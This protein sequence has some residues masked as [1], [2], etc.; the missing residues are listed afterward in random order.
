M[1][2]FES[3]ANGIR[4]SLNAQRS[5]P[6][7]E[8]F[9]QMYTST[10]LRYSVY[11]H[12]LVL[13]QSFRNLTPFIPRSVLL[14]K[15]LA[16]D[17]LPPLTATSEYNDSFFAGAEDIFAVRPRRRDARALERL[18]PDAGVRAQIEALF[19]ANPGLAGQLPGGVVQFVQMMAEMPDEALDDMMLGLAMGP[20]EGGGGVPG[21]GGMPGG[22][23]MEGDDDMPDLDPMPPRGAA[24][25]LADEDESEEEDEDEDEYIAPMPI[26]VVRNLLNRFWGGGG[27]AADGDESDSDVEERDHDG[28]D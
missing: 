21:G 2:W 24:P 9:L 10:T 3:T 18:I 16:C 6:T 11:R 27:A 13:E 23:P 8:R 1:K 15:Q 22:L 26:R 20:G 19:D 12:I 4:A 14:A 28:V 5:N 7:R 17:P 25:A